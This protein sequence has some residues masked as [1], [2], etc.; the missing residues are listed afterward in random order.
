MSLDLLLKLQTPTNTV[1]PLFCRGLLLCIFDLYQLLILKHIRP[2]LSRRLILIIYANVLSEEF[3][4]FDNQIG[5][6]IATPT[7][8]IS[9]GDDFF[10][11]ERN[12]LSIFSGHLF[13]A[14][15]MGVVKFI[16]VCIQHITCVRSGGSIRLSC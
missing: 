15:T 3:V 7:R 10:P 11:R 13:Y 9:H 16:C 12:I 14:G 4:S 2:S 6:W 1:H 5:S 8:E